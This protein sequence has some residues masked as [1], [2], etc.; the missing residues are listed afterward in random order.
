[1]TRRC[2]GAVAGDKPLPGSAPMCV[3]G[4]DEE[5]GLRPLKN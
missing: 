1:M 3:V 5:L 2:F 4:E